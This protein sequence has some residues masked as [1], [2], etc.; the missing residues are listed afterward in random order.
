MRFR[1]RKDYLGNAW[2]GQLFALERNKRGPFDKELAVRLFVFWKK[3]GNP[4][5]RFPVEFQF[6]RGRI[7]EDY[8]SV[9]FP[10]RKL[11]RRLTRTAR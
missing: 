8:R 2:V 5:V 4:Y 9:V 1:A 10:K 7:L 6:N 3:S 11:P